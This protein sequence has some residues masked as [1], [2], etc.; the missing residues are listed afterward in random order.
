MQW[1]IGEACNLKCLHCYQESHTPI[2]LEYDQL[3]SILNQYR[4]LLKKLD[5][6]GHINLTGGEPLCSPHFYKLLEEFK[7]DSDLYSFSILTNG[8]LITP[9]V[10]E[11]I[12]SYNPEYVQVS[13][14][15]G[16]RTNDYIRGKGVYKKVGKA[17]DSLKK[18]GIFVSI[19]FTATKINCKE[20]PKVV[21]FAKK[22]KVDNVWSDRFIPLGDEKDVELIMDSKETAAYLK[23][24][25]AER[26]K[27]MQKHSKTRISM[28]R[29][30]QFIFTNDYPYQCTA[31]DSLLTVMENGD[32]VPCRRMPIVVGNL[33]SEDMYELY[34]NSPTLKML[35]EDTTPEDCK[36]CEH[37]TFCK[38]GL[39]CLTYA[40]YK[41]LNHKDVG[42]TDALY[43]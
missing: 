10:A 17:I 40:L 42:C 31:G 39:K 24:M 5:V 19:S 33:L 25:Q 26:F 8:T 38:G 1:H 36:G 43:E 30:L 16:K 7:K 37:E 18:F 4:Q 41:D 21:K 9:E 23:L 15:G 28:Y 14:E 12:S 27:L 35:R 20:F 11:K 6:K 22:H 32:L 2:Q 13:L 29:A 34:M 3:L